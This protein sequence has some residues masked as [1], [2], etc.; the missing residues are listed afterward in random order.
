[1]PSASRICLISRSWS[2][3]S[4][5]VKPDFSFTSSAWRRRICAETEW[6]V[7]NQRRP[8]PS[9]P[10]SAS[11]RS[12][13]SRAALLVKVTTSIWLGQALARGED[14]GDARGQHPRLARARAGEHQ[15]RAVDATSPP[16][17][18]RGSGP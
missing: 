16:R 17:A 4:S 2:S 10:I 6:K 13:I 18:A 3:V 1:M 11:V 9:G 15:Q 12:R 7:P 14:V 8:S 5:T